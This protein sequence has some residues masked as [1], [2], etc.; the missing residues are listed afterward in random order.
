MLKPV[1]IVGSPFRS[2]KTKGEYMKTETINQLLGITESY[3]APQRMLELMLDNDKRPKLFEA[4][5]EHE[6]D[7]SY[8][9]FQSYFEDEHSDRK[10]KKQD[11]TP[12][13]VSELLARLTGQTDTYFESTAGTGGIMIKSWLE[14]KDNKGRWYKVEELSDRSIPFLIFNMAIRGLNGVV[15]HGDSLTRKFKDVYF[16]R[17]MN[18]EGFSEVIKMPHT[19]ALKRELNIRKWIL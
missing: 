10:V 7:L 14:N 12:N 6:T 2:Q 19:D 11:F 18:F 1:K 3:Q 5:L 4:F 9:W 16:I 13:S 17:N 8:E 15:L